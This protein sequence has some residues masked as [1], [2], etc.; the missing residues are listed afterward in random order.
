M[1]PERRFCRPKIYGH[2]WQASAIFGLIGGVH[3]L[4]GEMDEVES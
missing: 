1:K 2:L 4:P 3:S